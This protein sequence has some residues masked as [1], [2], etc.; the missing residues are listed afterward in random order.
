MPQ[1]RLYELLDWRTKINVDLLYNALNKC[2]KENGI[3]LAYDDRA[4]K[5]V[6]A[7][8]TYLQ[9]SQEGQI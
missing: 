6:D 3:Q 1:D 5:F 9:E 4:E 2:A 8:A 7:I